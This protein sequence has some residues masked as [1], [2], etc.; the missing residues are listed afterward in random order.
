PRDGAA[1]LRAPAAH[2]RRDDLEGAHRRE[3][4]AGLFR[5]RRARPRRE[6]ERARRPEADRRRPRRVCRRDGHGV[7]R[8]ARALRPPPPPHGPRANRLA[9]DWDAA[10]ITE[11]NVL[12]LTVLDAVPIATLREVIDWGPF[13]IAWEMK[14]KYPQ[15]LDDPE[16]GAVARELFDDAN[17]LLDRI[18][19]E[20]LLHVRAVAGLW[21]ANAD[22]DDLV[23]RT[24]GG[25]VRLHTLRQQTAKTP[26]KP[27]R[28]L[29]D[30]VAPADS[31]RRDYVGGF[32]VSV[33]GVAD[34][35]RSFRADHD[36]YR[37]I[38]TQTLGDRL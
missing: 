38:L 17:A 18:E 9:L 7:R 4:R 13:F 35:V 32:C 6:P 20:G 8:R 29:A 31:G 16:R 34:L 27:N 12:G 19:A 33:H 15:I 3:G 26:G 10:P 30:F 36:E 5:P 14:G 25:E 2:R 24:D 21:P 23:L 11:R 1:R 22:G 37:A 28:A